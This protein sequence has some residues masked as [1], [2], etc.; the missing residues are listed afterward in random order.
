MLKI[1]KR[2]HE[3]NYSLSVELELLV[4]TTPWQE[5]LVQ[6]SGTFQNGV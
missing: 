5:S 6:I 3:S 2:Y 4:T 1:G